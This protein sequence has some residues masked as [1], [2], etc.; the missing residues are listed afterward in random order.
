MATFVEHRIDD[1]L[2][3]T[4]RFLAVTVSGSAYEPWLDEVFRGSRL[5]STE[6]GR[7]TYSR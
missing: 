2:P 1:A 4:D 7:S 5:S 6:V 3:S